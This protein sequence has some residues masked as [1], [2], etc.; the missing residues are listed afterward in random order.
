MQRRDF[1]GGLAA[2]VGL[3]G[4]RGSEPEPESDWWEELKASFPVEDLRN[5]Y[6][7]AK[8][9]HVEYYWRSYHNTVLLPNGVR[10]PALHRDLCVRVHRGSKIDFGVFNNR[11]GYWDISYEVE[12]QAGVR[13]Y[14]PICVSALPR[15]LI[16]Y[17]SDGKGNH[18]EH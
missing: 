17:G 3:A 15:S 4:S 13:C 7:V 14:E 5:P 2:L 16:S 18:G 9:D 10:I 1:L 12:P 11:T 6:K 8:V